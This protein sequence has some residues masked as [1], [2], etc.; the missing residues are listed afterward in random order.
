MIVDIVEGDITAPENTADIIIGMNS[1]LGDVTGI[2]RPFV[3]TLKTTHP[4]QLGCVLSFEF[5]DSRQLH[6]IICHHIGMGGWEGSDMHVRFGLDYL[7][8]KPE[9]ALR[10]FSIVKIGSGRVG[11]RDGANSAAI[12]TAM[13]TSFLP[14]TLFLFNKRLQ[15]EGVEALKK[16]PLRALCVWNPKFGE[17]VLLAA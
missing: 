13:T 1:L 14:V 11:Q 7:W 6:M 15:G 5:D 10:K 16:P 2:G 4:I 3:N 8:Q 17:E 12:L 9:H